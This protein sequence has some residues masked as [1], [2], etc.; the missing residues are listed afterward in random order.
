MN[1]KEYDKFKID[2]D[3]KEEDIANIIGCSKPTVL[4]KKY[5]DLFTIDDIN[6]IIIKF[7]LPKE[8]VLNIF[9]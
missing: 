4:N 6:K 8:R 5:K 3:L 7:K 9:F 2:Y 1:L